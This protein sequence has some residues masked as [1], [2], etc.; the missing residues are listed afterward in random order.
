LMAVAAVT[1]CPAPA[2]VNL[3]LKVISK[4]PDG[5]HNLVSIVDL[6][7]LYDSLQVKELKKD[8][9]LVRTAWGCYPKGLRI[10]F[11]RR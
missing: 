6:I 1:S 11:T 7:S 5:Y 10:P 3:M 8:E 9:I 2:K 4:R